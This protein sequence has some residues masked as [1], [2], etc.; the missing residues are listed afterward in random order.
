MPDT[1]RGSISSGWKFTAYIKNPDPTESTG[2]YRPFKGYRGGNAPRI[3]IFDNASYEVEEIP[4]MVPVDTR[5]VWAG[6]TVYF[7]SD[8]NGRTNVFYAYNRET[9]RSA[10]GDQGIGITM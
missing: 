3:W 10:T 4:M 6:N 8:R 5:P 9:K 7:L 1:I 2:T